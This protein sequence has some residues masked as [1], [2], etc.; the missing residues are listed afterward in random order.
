MMRKQARAFTMLAVVL[1]RIIQN[2]ACVR[3][4]FVNPS[5][6]L[7]Y[8]VVRLSLEWVESS[9]ESGAIGFACDCGSSRVIR[10]SFGREQGSWH[11]VSTVVMPC[12]SRQDIAAIAPR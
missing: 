8:T 4:L 9:F 2:I 10:G 6:F 12:D 5:K 7:A 1:L 3:D 11:P